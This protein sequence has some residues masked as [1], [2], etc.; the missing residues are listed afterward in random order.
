MGA[1]FAL[2]ALGGASGPE[3]SPPPATGAETP[4]SANAG[5]QPNA[6]DMLIPGF[7]FFT[8]AV[9][10]YLHVDLNVYIPLFVTLA[11]IVLGWQY[12]SDWFW[13]KMDS[14]LMSKC[15]LR[16][17]D[18]AYNYV[19]AWVA[20][21]QFS[22]KSRRFIV[23]TNTNSRNY[24]IWN[25]NDDQKEDEDDSDPDMTRKPLA[26]TPDYGSHYF[27]Y[28]RTLLCFLR[29]QGRE[30]PYSL[31]SE[32]EEIY[33][34]CFGRNPA[35]LKDLLNEARDV[36][37]KRDEKKTAIYRGTVAKGASA[38]PTWSRC[39]ARTSRPFSTVILNEKVKQD[40]ID[41][42]TDYLDPATRRWYS[43]RGIPYRR[44]YLLHGPPGTG[45]SSLSLALA[46]F[47]KMRIYIVSLSSVNANEETLATLFAELP[48][49]CV[50]LLED[51]DSAGLSHTRE[52]PSSAAVAPAPAAAEELVPGQLTPGLPN[53]A[54]NSRISLS[55]LLNIL[56]GVASQ[57]GRVLIMTTNHIEKLDKALIR[58]GRVD[59]I[60]HF[61]RA[62]R[63]MIASIFKAIYAPLEGDEGPE[64]KKTSSAATAAT[65][66]KDDN[67]EEA[68]AA[69]DKEKQEAARRAEET[70]ARIDN[71][72]ARFADR[73]PAHEFSPA[74]LQG[75]LMKHKRDAE[76]AVAG[77]DD[78]VVAARKEKAEK[79]VE[80][81][82]ERRRKEEENKEEADKKKRK[83]EED[84]EEAEKK[85][86]KEERKKNKTKRAKKAA[87]SKQ[88]DNSDSSGSDTAEPGDEG[89]SD[90]SSDEEASSKTRGKSRG[91][92]RRRNAGRKAKMQEEG[93][94]PGDQESAEPSKPEEPKQL[95][96]SA[97]AVKLGQHQD[98]A[99]PPRSPVGGDSGYE[100]C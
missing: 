19:M 26:Y 80:D 37:L 65:I 87:A 3:T 97:A 61:G 25:W 31:P 77:A 49:R 45:K 70:L 92:K 56:D 43:N 38:E 88:E 8:A 72:A 67:D 34:S 68:K 15:S 36:Y 40:L 5:F 52:G 75:Y 23:N 35:I 81:A 14:Y 98:D 17:D 27:F 62:D 28:K 46:G 44:G 41:D 82:K 18:E 50:V 58:P 24:F 57:E 71:L 4:A 21:Q 59:M 10:R 51:I 13:S 79:E 22:Q 63:A 89:G 93:E 30:N 74:E 6:L 2:N 83:E 73:I 32:K 95:L 16:T 33:I 7:S 94:G 53:A 48:R 12:L 29:S 39:M 91:A 76:A 100:T 78:W 20:K 90:D 99:K 42:V 1:Y 85:K 64:T 66:G 84:K 47:F 11:A 96:P 86:R 9:Q 54:T 60:V 55:G 69:A